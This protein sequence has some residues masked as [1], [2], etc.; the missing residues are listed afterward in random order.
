MMDDMSGIQL[1][2]YPQGLYGTLSRLCSCNLYTR[3]D[4]F[5]YAMKPEIIYI[6]YPICFLVC[7]MCLRWL[8]FVTNILFSSIISFII[9][10]LLY[11]P[12]TYSIYKDKVALFYYAVMIL[13]LLLIMTY[14]IGHGFN[15]VADH[16]ILMQCDHTDPDRQ[17]LI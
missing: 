3:C 7:Y 8:P 17:C 13:T 15:V 11:I 4:V 14:A 2:I 16:T 9:I 1:G 10:N 5:K 12:D 6:I